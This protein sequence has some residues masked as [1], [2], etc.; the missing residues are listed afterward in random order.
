[1]GKKISNS[2][3]K[4]KQSRK[5]NVMKVPFLLRRNSINQILL[6]VGSSF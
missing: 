6:K 1:M 5:M 3:N 2:Q 4:D